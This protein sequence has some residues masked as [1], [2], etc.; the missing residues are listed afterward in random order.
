FLLLGFIMAAFLNVPTV[1]IA[2]AACAAAGVWDVITEDQ[3]N[4]PAPAAASAA[5][6]DDD[7]EYDL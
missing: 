4:Q 2:L 7:E 3:K 6:S 1:G 5:G